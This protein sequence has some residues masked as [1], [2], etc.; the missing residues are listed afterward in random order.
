MALR[1][2]KAFSVFPT[3]QMNGTRSL[4]EVTVRLGDKE[5]AFYVSA[6]GLQPAYGDDLEWGTHHVDVTRADGSR[7]TL[8]KIGYDFDPNAPI[9]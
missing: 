6:D 7:F 1:K 4:T 2:G 3:Q 8:R 5:V 9:H